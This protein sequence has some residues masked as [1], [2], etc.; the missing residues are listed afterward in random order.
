[1]DTGNYNPIKPKIQALEGNKSE[2]ESECERGPGD[3]VFCFGTF[4]RISLLY[5]EGFNATYH[6]VRVAN[7]TCLWLQLSAEEFAEVSVVLQ[8]FYCSFLHIDPE[9]PYVQIIDWLSHPGG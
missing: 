8:I 9:R 6:T 7:R 1:M 4:F 3:L 5:L 2:V